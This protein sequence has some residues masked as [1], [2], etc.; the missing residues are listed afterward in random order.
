MSCCGRNRSLLKSSTVGTEQVSV[1][2][3]PRLRWRRQVAATVRGPATRREYAVTPGSVIIVDAADVVALLRSGFF[4][5]V[6]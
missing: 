4:E 3:P 6:G 1:R 5:R 2:T